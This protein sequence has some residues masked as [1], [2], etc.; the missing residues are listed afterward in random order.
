MARQPENMEA[1][2]SDVE[3]CLAGC[4]SSVTPPAFSMPVTDSG[5]DVVTVASP[6]LHGRVIPLWVLKDGLLGSC[7][8]VEQRD[9]LEYMNIRDKVSY[10]GQEFG[11]TVYN[12]FTAIGCKPCR[13]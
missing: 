12:Q 3:E 13:L 2:D 7:M 5:A 6:L 11:R 8:Y 10:R 9:W 4:G 1:N